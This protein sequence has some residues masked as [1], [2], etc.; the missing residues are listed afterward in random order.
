MNT[1]VKSI[2]SYN[3]IIVFVTA[4]TVFCVVA[5]AETQKEKELRGQLAA[6]QSAQ[7]KLAESVGKLSES[8]TRNAKNK[9]DYVKAAE[10]AAKNAESAK[11]AAS[12]AADKAVGAAN[13]IEAKIEILQKISE[14][15]TNNVLITEVSGF[16]VVLIGLIFKAYT[17]SRDHN[18]AKASAIRTETLV[19]EHKSELEQVKTEAR[20]AYVAANGFAEKLQVVNDKLNN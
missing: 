2:K 14:Q 12:L 7:S 15:G 18:W 19:V 6:S 20:L 5:L 8:S 1:N 4:L 9:A 11:E 16:A 17:D 10:L 3:S 13:R